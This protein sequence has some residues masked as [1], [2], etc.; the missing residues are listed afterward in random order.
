M[1]D[2]GAYLLAHREQH[3]DELKELLRYPSVSA[4]SAHR[5]DIWACAGWLA[6]ALTAAGMQ[7]ARL[8]PTGGHPVV[9]AE[10]LGAGPQAPTA[11]VYG[12]YDVQPV[13][14]LHLWQT[15]P[16][17]PSIRDGKIY[18]RGA[19][20]DKTQIFM[21]IKAAEALMRLDGRLP[22]NL[23]LLFEGEEEVGSANLASFIDAHRDLLR[24]DVVV[25]ADS[26]LYAR[27][28]PAI[29]V[30]LRGLVHVQVDL[31]GANA[32][33]HSGLFGG[34]V[35]N[36]L[37]ALV[38]LLS[39]LRGPDGRI[40][41]EGF[42]DRVRPLSADDRLQLA[43]APFDEAGYMAGLGVQ[44]LFGEAGYTTIE[45]SRARPT[46]EFNGIWGGFTGEGTKTVL[47][48][49]AHAK[50]SCRLVPDQG[51]DEIR[52][53]IEAHLRKHR[54]PGVTMQIT[55]HPGAALPI[56]VATDHPATRAATAALTGAYGRECLFTRMGASVPVVEI[57]K[58]LL[59]LDA[60]LMGFALE[61][62]NL[63]A[64]NEH[65]HLENFDLG[66]RALCSYWSRLAAAWP[67]AGGMGRA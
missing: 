4:L 13:D 40:L 33:L 55:S 42:Y 64:P 37:H 65:F 26:G 67:V 8:M 24:A 17:S 10:W 22:V 54:P 66:L 62:E 43:A 14:P 5:E 45:R 53:L 3:L 12:H 11:L 51:P 1:S 29:T 39:T 23:K 35:Q 56:L 18:A 36:A 27:G 31:R 28:V 38:Q 61:T 41:V 57:F 60:V 32:D 48:C 44:E 50:L 47:P 20:D 46:L 21:H 34:A 52:Q 9:Y 16:F 58:R 19:S 15:P 25:V 2:Y 6:A 30:G 7:E 63:H 49:E 59:G